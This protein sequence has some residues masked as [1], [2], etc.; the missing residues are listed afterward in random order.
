M[1]NKYFFINLP[2]RT[3]SRYPSVTR[4]VLFLHCGEDSFLY[5]ASAQQQ[6]LQQ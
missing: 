3:S 6:Q 1:M 2:I 5:R 4:A